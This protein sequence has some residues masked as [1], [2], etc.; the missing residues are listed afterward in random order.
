MPDILPNDNA[1]VIV[2]RFHKIWEK[3][4]ITKD[5]P[6]LMK[7]L[8]YTCPLEITLAAVFRFIAAIGEFAN[9]LL[10]Q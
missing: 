3:D 10:L 4:A 2:D 7:A 1:R 5:N 9:P 8:I 6:S